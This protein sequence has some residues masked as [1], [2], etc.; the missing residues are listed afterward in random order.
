MKV[1]F[2]SILILVTSMK[3]LITGSSGGIGFE[4]GKRLISEGHFVYFTV[5]LDS[6]IETLIEKLK[7]LKS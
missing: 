3:I 5:H 6:Q 2:F 1:F 4:V 7:E